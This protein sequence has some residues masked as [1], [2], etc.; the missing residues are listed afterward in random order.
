MTNNF[1]KLILVLIFAFLSNTASAKP[2]I[3]VSITPIGSL[4]AILVQDKANVIVINDSA[5]CPHEHSIKP[6]DKLLIEKADMVIYVDENF[7]NLTSSIMKNY[8]GKKVRISDF[9]SINFKGTDEI[10]NWHFWLDLENVKALEQNLAAIIVQHFPEIKEDVEQ[11]LSEALSGIQKLEKL[12]QS[13]LTNLAPMV[14]LSDSL[15]HFFKSL[16]VDYTKHFHTHNNSLKN[17]KKLNSIFESNSAKCLVLDAEQNSESYEKYG[18]LIIQLDSENWSI[19]DEASSDVTNA[20]LRA[21]FVNKYMEMIDKLSS[22][23]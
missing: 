7:D 5:G 10:T 12:K 4:T 20:G 14:L 17:I 6:S 16:K 22:C 2:N 15:E 1:K 3:L 18:K 11:N 8:Q 23:K 9:T 13:K 19:P 21:L